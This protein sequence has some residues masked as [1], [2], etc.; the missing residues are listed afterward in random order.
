MI[1]RCQIRIAVVVMA[2]LAN[3]PI[4]AAQSPDPDSPRYKAVVALSD[5]LI[6]R[7]DEALK[8][9]IDVR[10]SPALLGSIGRDS[11][12]SALDELR[13]GF[14]GAQMAGARPQ[15]P[16]GAYISFSNDKSLSFEM[17]ADPPHRFV[18]IGSL[19][20]EGAPSNAAPDCALPA[21]L[22]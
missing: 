3:L 18:R 13:S 15:G 9:F 7:G 21:G 14:S 8:Q 11:L 17:E 16:N 2:V 5:F 22:V 20:G 19:G 12:A 10:V 1:D 4:A 6:S